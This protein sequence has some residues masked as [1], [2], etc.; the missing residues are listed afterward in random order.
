MSRKPAREAATI[1]ATAFSLGGVGVLLRGASGAGKSRL[2]F[3]LIH[4]AGCQPSREAGHPSRADTAL[5]G[6][7]R[8]LLSQDDGLVASPPPSLAGLI[9]LRGIGL[10]GLPWRAPARLHLVADLMPM[11]KVERMPEDVAITLQGHSLAYL[12]VP[13][14]DL[15]HQMLIIRTA[16]GLING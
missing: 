11:D 3:A 8:I 12:R 15:A 4:A 10:L 7:D 14:G 13:V 5:I 2:A 16:A 9:E 1:H 6:D